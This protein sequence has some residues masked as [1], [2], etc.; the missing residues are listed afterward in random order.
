MCDTSSFSVNP[1]SSNI[2]NIE[3]KGYTEWAWLVTP[4]RSGKGHLKLIIKVRVDEDIQKDIVV[5][6][7]KIDVNPDRVYSVKIWISKYWQFLIST[8]IIPFIIWLFKR[9]KEKEE[10]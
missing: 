9:R 7:K 2:Q 10:D 6:D 4:L 3:D 5:F 1:L 8:I